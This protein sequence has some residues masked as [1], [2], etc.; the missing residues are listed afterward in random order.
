M[1]CCGHAEIVYTLQWIDTA[2]VMLYVCLKKVKSRL[3]QSTYNEF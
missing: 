2:V 3:F 1:E